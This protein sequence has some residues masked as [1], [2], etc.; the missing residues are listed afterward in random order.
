MEIIHV[1]TFAQPW[2]RSDCRGQY[3]IHTEPE[4]VLHV[5]LIDG[6]SCVVKPISRCFPS[7]V[8][9]GSG[10]HTHELSNGFHTLI[11]L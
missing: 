3:K 9:G 7:L 6:T 5:Y 10:A 2:V 1:K 8:T 11:L 4:Q